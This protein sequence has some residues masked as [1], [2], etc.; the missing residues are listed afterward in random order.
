MS[1]I[2]QPE[3]YDRIV[4]MY[5]IHQLELSDRLYTYMSDIPQPE[6]YMKGLYTCLTYINLSYMT[7][8]VQKNPTKFLHN[9]ITQFKNSR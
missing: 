2:P 7:G 8:L 1:D 3:F 6:L 9:K 4:N 5:D